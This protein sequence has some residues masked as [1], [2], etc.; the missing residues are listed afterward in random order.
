MDRMT[1]SIIDHLFAFYV[2]LD[3]SSQ[4]FSYLLH[5]APWQLAAT[6]PLYL[7]GVPDCARMESTFMVRVLWCGR[8]VDRFDSDLPIHHPAHGPLTGVHCPSPTTWFQDNVTFCAQCKYFMV[9][10]CTV[11]NSNLAQFRF[12]CL[13]CGQSVFPVLRVVCT[14]EAIH[15]EGYCHAQGMTRCHDQ[16]PLVQ[17]TIICAYVVHSH[18]CL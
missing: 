18:L 16:T 4:L 9:S 5:I 15:F 17:C 6:P 2:S 12:Q 1:D 11:S 14:W 7:Q 3:L 13:V 8:S 10:S